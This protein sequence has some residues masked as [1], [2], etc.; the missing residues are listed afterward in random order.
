[1]DNFYDLPIFFTFS[2]DIFKNTY[3]KKLISLLY[4]HMTFQ[5]AT[6]GLYSKLFR[7]FHL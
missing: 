6:A 5:I 4:K 1:M 2:A 3:S 7:Q